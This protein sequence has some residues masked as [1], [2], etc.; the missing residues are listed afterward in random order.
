MEWILNNKEWLFSGIGVVLITTILNFIPKRDSD[1]KLNYKFFVNLI[2]GIIV[3]SICDYHINPNKDFRLSIATYL[4]SIIVLFIVVI[5]IVMIA[6]SIITRVKTHISVKGLTLEDCRYVVMCKETNQYFQMD[7]TNY[8]EFEHKWNNILYIKH[9]SK[10]L[11]YQKYRIFIKPL[12][13]KLIK[14][15]LKK[16]DDYEA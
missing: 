3:G 15:R 14:K 6:N 9:G 10:I 7:W 12:A 2:A 4:I 5:V 8:A 11:M 16:E 1:Y 13:W